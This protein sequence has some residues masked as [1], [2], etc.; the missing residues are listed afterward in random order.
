MVLAPSLS[1]TVRCSTRSSI[2]PI[3]V[4]AVRYLIAIG[5]HAQDRN[6]PIPGQPQELQYPECRSQEGTSEH[7][8]MYG[9]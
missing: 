3:L 1:N 6:Q 9:W 2:L 4:I 7:Q 5:Q 8:M